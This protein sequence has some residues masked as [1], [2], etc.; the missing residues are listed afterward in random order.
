MPR[1]AKYTTNADGRVQCP[2]CTTTFSTVPACS[3]HVKQFHTT[4]APQVINIPDTQPTPKVNTVD[5]EQ[6]EVIVWIG[7]DNEKAIKSALIAGLHAMSQ[8]KPQ[9]PKQYQPKVKSYLDILPEDCLR[10]I[11]KNVFDECIEQLPRCRVSYREFNPKWDYFRRKE[12]FQ[13]E[14][15][16]RHILKEF[17]AIQGDNNIN[18]CGDIIQGNKNGL[19]ALYK[20]IGVTQASYRLMR[21]RTRVCECKGVK[22]WIPDYHTDTEEKRTVKRATI[23]DKRQGFMKWE[24]RVT[25]YEY[26]NDDTVD[27]YRD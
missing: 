2:H 4:P 15:E 6:E 21:I 10:L 7:W 25:D 17:K 12:E 20:I 9:P 11:Y 18:K 3:R 23:D 24:P 16:T 8:P 13:H 27:P 22:Y 1:P 5:E 26:A 19:Y 14:W